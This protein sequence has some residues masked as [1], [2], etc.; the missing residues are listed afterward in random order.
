M[1]RPLNPTPLHTSGT[2]PVKFA[3]VSI[4]RSLSPR[5]FY[6]VNQTEG[7][8]TPF[9][10]PGLP[11]VYIRTTGTPFHVA[12][13]GCISLKRPIYSPERGASYTGCH[14]PNVYALSHF[15]A[16][17]ISSLHI[18]TFPRYPSAMQ[19]IFIFVVCSFLFTYL[20]AQ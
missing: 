11:I 9:L 14:H 5:R 4:L 10:P 3:L 17:G 8:C 15:L 18:W 2:G 6:C 12:F 13:P 1:F 16:L 19:F 20:H 7:S